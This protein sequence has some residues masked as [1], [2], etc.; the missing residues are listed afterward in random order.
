MNRLKLW[1]M[2]AALIC[3]ST[4]FTSCL[5]SE[6]NPVQEQAKKD[7]KEFI[8]HTRENLKYL[9]ENMNFGSWEA[10]NTI[11]QTF[12]TTV[13]NNPEFEKAII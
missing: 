6:D 5:S 11:N 7:R 2:A 13:L 10:A 9:A 12:N 8:Q 4:V 3:S 1:V